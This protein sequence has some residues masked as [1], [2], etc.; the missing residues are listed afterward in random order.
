MFRNSIHNLS[1]HV[2]KR[3]RL[4][5]LQPWLEARAAESN[6]DPC[7]HNALGK[8]YIDS[9]QNADDFLNHNEYYDH[10]TLG[11]YCENRDPMLA[12]VAY[13]RGVQ[14]RAWGLVGDAGMNLAFAPSPLLFVWDLCGTCRPRHGRDAGAEAVFVSSRIP[15]KKDFPPTVR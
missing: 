5:L 4:K 7:L 3:N 14:Q 1:Q 13:Q 11:K 15:S 12:F 8:I 10:L 2:E 9:N 6:K